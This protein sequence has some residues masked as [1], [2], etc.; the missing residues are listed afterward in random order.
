MLTIGSG[1]PD[2]VTAETLLS[3]QPKAEVACGLVLNQRQTRLIE[4]SQE[5]N[6]QDLISGEDCK[7]NGK[8]IK[9]TSR[10]HLAGEIKAFEVQEL[11]NLKLFMDVFQ[12]SL[13]ELRISSIAPLQEYE[14]NN[15]SKREQLWRNVK[16][17]VEA[18][19]S[20]MRARADNIRMEPPFI[21][22]LKSLLRILARRQL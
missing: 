4:P 3:S 10:I 17:R 8:L 1:F 21:L 9:T 20:N 16:R 2:N 12:N 19:L 7:I 11:N 13:N 14:Y 22:G 6:N 5:A 18:D 15:L